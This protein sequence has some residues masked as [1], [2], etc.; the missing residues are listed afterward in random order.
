M[1]KLVSLQHCSNLVVMVVMQEVI[2]GY[3]AP[4]LPV[5]LCCS[6]CCSCV[7]TIPLHMHLASWYTFKTVNLISFDLLEVC[8]DKLPA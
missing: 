8:M 1:I 7:Y 3:E 6:V 2:S 5:A 4:L